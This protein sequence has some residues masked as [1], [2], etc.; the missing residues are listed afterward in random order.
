MEMVEEGGGDDAGDLVVDGVVL[1]INDHL[2]TY[3]LCSW[4]PSYKVMGTTQQL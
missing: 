1:L 3:F 2:P 4:W